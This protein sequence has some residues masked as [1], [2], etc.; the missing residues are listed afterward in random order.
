MTQHSVLK[1]SRSFSENAR[2][3]VPV[4]L[5]D[6][7]SRHGRV[8]SHPRLKA[9]FHKMRIAGK[10][11]RYAMEVFAEVLDDEFGSCLQEVKQLLTTMGAVHDCDVN[12]P[13]V[14]TQLR[15]IRSFNRGTPNP[16]DRITTTA[17][18]GLIA[19]QHKLRS[20]KF[21]E[22]CAVIGR[23]IDG[24]F[25]DRVVRSMNPPTAS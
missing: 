16:E 24:G 7:L 23:W 25:R 20:E 21:N 3:L 9:D 19:M 5:D 8:L 15:E 4:L 1:P 11:L 22:A 2:L 14:Q 10:T 13:R 12:I 17:L 18:V 6:F